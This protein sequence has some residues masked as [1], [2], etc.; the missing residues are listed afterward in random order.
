LV[1]FIERLLWFGIDLGFTPAI[2]DLHIMAEL[3]SMTE[4]PETEMIGQ[5]AQVETEAHMA[6][7][8]GWF[9]QFS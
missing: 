1:L 2:L 9:S 3:P 7:L 6:A 5:E 4:V 8:E